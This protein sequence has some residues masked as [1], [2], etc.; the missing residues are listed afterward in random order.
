M[1]IGIGTYKDASF[2]PIYGPCGVENYLMA[3]IETMHEAFEKQ[4]LFCPTPI[5]K[6]CES[7]IGMEVFWP[8]KN[9]FLND[10]LLVMVSH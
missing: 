9:V 4:K 1:K 3:S 7:M 5:A 6:Y 10:E 8:F 2:V